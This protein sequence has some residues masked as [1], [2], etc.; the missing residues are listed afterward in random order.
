MYMDPVMHLYL[1]RHLLTIV[2]VNVE[3]TYG[4]ETIGS[5]TDQET[6]LPYVIFG[7]TMYT[8]Y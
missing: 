5:H 4:N 3:V 1:Q 7:K 2:M 6:C 8:F